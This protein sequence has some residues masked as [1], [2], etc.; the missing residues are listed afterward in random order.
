MLEKAP[1]TI[2]P[3]IAAFHAELTQWRRDLHAHPET[4]FEENRTADLV[5][6]RLESFGIAVHR[7]LARTGVVAPDRAR[8]RRDRAARRHG[9]A[10]H[11]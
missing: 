5:A 6:E 2:I 1:M 9:C 3:E 10:A 7:G 8:Q 11:P 4:A